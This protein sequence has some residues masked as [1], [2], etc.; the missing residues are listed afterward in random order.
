MPP[1]SNVY[2]SVQIYFH[3]VSKFTNRASDSTRI[4]LLLAISFRNITWQFTENLNDDV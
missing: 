4:K 3:I 1:D 2:I